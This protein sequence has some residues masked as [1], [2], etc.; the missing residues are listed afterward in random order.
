MIV[1]WLVECICH[2]R[3]A[4]QIGS[5]CSR[6]SFLPII[7]LGFFCI[8]VGLVNVVR[9]CTLSSWR[10]QQTPAGLVWT[11]I[12]RSVTLNIGWHLPVLFL[13][14]NCVLCI[15]VFPL[16]SPQWALT[17]NW[18][19]CSCL[20]TKLDPLSSFPTPP[21]SWLG[22]DAKALFLPQTGAQRPEYKCASYKT[23][24]IVGIKWLF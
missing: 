4:N 8:L 16:F 15:E 20:K 10:G 13:T 21:S 2:L 14:H 24:S 3:F 23:G 18:S 17:Q 1:S 5:P 9:R 6:Q 22:H 11:E 7:C 12:N 19:L